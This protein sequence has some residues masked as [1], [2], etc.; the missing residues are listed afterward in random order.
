MQTLRLQ[1]QLDT[2]LFKR[3]RVEK[4]LEASEDK[5]KKAKEEATIA[6][7]RLTATLAVSLLIIAA[8]GLVGYIQLTKR[9]KHHPL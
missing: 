8:L 9:K 3:K 6:H 5:L 7:T 4:D 1:A 2:E